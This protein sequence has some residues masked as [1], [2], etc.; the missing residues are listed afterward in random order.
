MGLGIAQF[1]NFTLS[2]GK[3]HVGLYN[4]L[5]NDLRF[6]S[7]GEVDRYNLPHWGLAVV[8]STDQPTSSLA[9]AVMFILLNSGLHHHGYLKEVAETRPATHRG[10][11]TSRSSH[12]LP[13]PAESTAEVSDRQ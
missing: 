13:L 2:F 8:F 10:L 3:L 12:T 1:E 7:N 5:L 4:L 9:H 11:Y 6:L